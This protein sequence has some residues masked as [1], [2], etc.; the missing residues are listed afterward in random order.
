MV[1][2]VR[3]VALGEEPKPMMYVPYKQ[4]AFPGAVLV[5]KSSLSETSLVATIRS[6]VA[7]LDKDLPVSNVAMMADALDNSVAEPWFR[8]FLL[9]LFAGL[10][11]LLAAIGIFGVI[12]YS[13][14]CRTQEIGIR[15][16]M[17]ASRGAIV[18]MVLPKTVS[19]LAGGLALGIPGALVASRLLGHLLFGVSASDPFTLSAVVSVLI[20]VAAAA[21]YIPT[22]RALRVDPVV[23]LRHDWQLRFGLHLDPLWISPDDS[24]FRELHTEKQL[25]CGGWNR[26]PSS[27]KPTVHRKNYEKSG[28]KFVVDDAVRDG[29]AVTRA[30]TDS[31]G[32]S[33]AG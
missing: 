4:A 12:S 2:D 9:T 18:R 32:V 5:V 8:T 27:T 26:E 15:V 1:G 7:K 29:D 16:A 24:A 23:A 14:A 31:A 22:L 6:D 20:A 28:G 25:T 30:I 10:A 17:G 3:D 33:G 19:L 13:V 11:L 21:S